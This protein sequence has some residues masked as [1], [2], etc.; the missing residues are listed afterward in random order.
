MTQKLRHYANSGRSDSFD[1]QSDVSSTQ[2]DTTDTESHVSSSAGAWGDDP[3][4]KDKVRLAQEEQ[5]LID[6]E[7][8]WVILIA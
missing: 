7:V 8:D 1:Q 5:L 2:G 6:W 4:I 3:E